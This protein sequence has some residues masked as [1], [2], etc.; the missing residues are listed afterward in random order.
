MSN[1]NPL[2]LLSIV[3]L[4][5]DMQQL[6]PEPVL[7]YWRCIYRI[8]FNF[9]LFCSCALCFSS[10][11]LLWRPHILAVA[12]F[13]EYIWKLERSTKKLLNSNSLGI[14]LSNN[15]LNKYERAEPQRGDVRS[16]RCLLC[17][18][19]VCLSSPPLRNMAPAFCCSAAKWSLVHALVG[20]WWKDA[21]AWRQH[22]L[23]HNTIWGWRNL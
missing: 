18:V 7:I 22:D 3:L 6:Y 16:C 14:E 11:L 5:D 21:N 23:C 19:S 13:S 8:R 12:P 2:F 9:F 4:A 20:Y 15:L 10:L 17:A 1:T